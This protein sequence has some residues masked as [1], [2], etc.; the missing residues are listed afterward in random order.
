LPGSH[1]SSSIDR[2]SEHS[3]P[4]DVPTRETAAFLASHLSAHSVVLEVGCGEGDVAL[5]LVSLGHRVIAIDADAETVARARARGVSATFASWP[6]FEAGEVDAVAFT[7]SLHHIGP[8]APAI[9]R[10][11]RTLG[12]RGVLLVEDFAF[13]SA[14]PKVIAELVAMLPAS[15]SRSLI[16]PIEGELI[17]DLLAGDDVERVWR[18]RHARFDLHAFGTM[19]EAVRESFEDVEWEGCP[20]LYRYLVRVLTENSSKAAELVEEVLRWE[21]ARGEDAWIGRRIVAC[22]GSR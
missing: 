5:A 10:A 8:L 16:E 14:D 2:P 7:R 6:D 1:S 15:A 9:E 13:E 21:V 17:A 22:P 12:P 3:R 19:L 18:E 11:R 20:Y 4:I